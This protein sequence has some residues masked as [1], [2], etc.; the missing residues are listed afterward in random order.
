MGTFPSAFDIGSAISRVTGASTGSINVGTIPVTSGGFNFP[1]FNIPPFNPPFTIPPFTLPPTA[2]PPTVPPPSPSPTANASDLQIMISAIPTAQDGQVITADFHNALRLALVAI[3]NRLGIGPVSDEVTITNAPR[4]SP[5]AGAAAW[6]H[7]VG[8]VRKPPA[9]TS[10]NVR[11]WM[12]MELP[13]GGRI[14]KMVVFATT[15]GTGTLKFR[16]RRQKVTD[17][18]V[19][20]DL[21]VIEI[22][23][24]FD[25]AKGAEGDVTVRDTGAG[26]VA[27]EEFRIIDNRQQKYL[28]TAELDGVDANTIG[29]FLCVQIVC[30]Q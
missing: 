6:D 27:I 11:G 30:G 13:H 3:A 15:T 14:K 26:T 28:L 22:P 29:Q 16:L 17:P 7:D 25:A 18:S 2:P 23:D 10:G 24:G 9:V 19:A 8:F 12:E 4:L 5:V 20:A 21:I 1:P